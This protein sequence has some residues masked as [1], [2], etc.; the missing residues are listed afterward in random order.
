[1]IEELKQFQEGNNLIKL[2]YINLFVFVL[3]KLFGVL[4]F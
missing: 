1:M 3:V 4:P 2:I